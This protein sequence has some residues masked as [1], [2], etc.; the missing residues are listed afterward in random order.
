MK[1]Y[2][3]ARDV[4]ANRPPTL[5]L[6]AETVEDQMKLCAMVRRSKREFIMLGYSCEPDND[7]ETLGVTAIRF[8]LMET[9]EQ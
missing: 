8:P 7:C 4:L 3:A 6:H 2:L 9:T 1:I 5:E